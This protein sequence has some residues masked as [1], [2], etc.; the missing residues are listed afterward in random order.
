M[1]VI[2]ATVVAVGTFVLVLPDVVL[3]ALLMGLAIVLGGCAAGAY[4]LFIR[5]FVGKTMKEFWASK[6]AK[7]AKAQASKQERAAK[8]KPIQ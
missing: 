6:D 2:G 8:Q 4:V 5:L 3:G 1:L 7:D